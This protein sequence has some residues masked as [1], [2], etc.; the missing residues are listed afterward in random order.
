MGLALIKLF[1]ILLNF[2]KKNTCV[3]ILNNIYYTIN[4]W[5][6]SIGLNFRLTTDKN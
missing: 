3:E 5:N 6:I 4:F 2:W 1:L